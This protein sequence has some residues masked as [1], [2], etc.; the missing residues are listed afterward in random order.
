MFFFSPFRLHN[1]T[2]LSVR[3]RETT[4]DEGDFMGVHFDQGTPVC[5]SV[6]LSLAL[7]V[8]L[9]R[10]RCGHLKSCLFIRDLH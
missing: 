6:F 9:Q 5:L 4:E 10:F 2:D 1:V 8:S 3:A 7:C